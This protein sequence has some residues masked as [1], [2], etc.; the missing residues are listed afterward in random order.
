MVCSPA[1]ELFAVAND[2]VVIR[3]RVSEI[4]V[5]GRDTMGV[6]MM[7]LTGDRSLVAV[8]RAAELEGTEDEE[9]DEPSATG[10]NVDADGASVTEEEQPAG[11]SVDAA[12][13]DVQEPAVVGESAPVEGEDE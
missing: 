7:R 8:A 2:G 5:T 10:A 3:T 11:D 1:D 13:D 12:P 6:S 4:R 9:L